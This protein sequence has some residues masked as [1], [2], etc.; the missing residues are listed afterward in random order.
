MH[1][2]RRH[3]PDMPGYIIAGRDAPDY[4]YAKAYADQTALDMRE[5]QFDA[6]SSETLSLL[7]TVAQTVEAFEPAIIRP[8]LYA[9]LIS[10]RIHEDGYP[11]RACAAKAP[12]NCSPVMARWN[13]PSRNQRR[14]AVMSRN[15]A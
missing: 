10:K 4:R 11:R 15:N 6:Q 1:Y 13:M 5:V 2:A 3:R 14:W 9:Y 8:S 7:E 12:T